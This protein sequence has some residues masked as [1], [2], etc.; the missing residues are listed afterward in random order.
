LRTGRI[1]NK[2]ANVS[3]TL[4]ETKKAMHVR[5]TSN[6]PAAHTAKYARYGSQ[7]DREGDKQND[8]LRI[9]LS[10]MNERGIVLYVDEKEKKSYKKSSSYTKLCLQKG[11]IHLDPLKKIARG[12][13]WLTTRLHNE[14]GE[15]TLT[16]RN[17]KLI[18]ALCENLQSAGGWINLSRAAEI[19]PDFQQELQVLYM[20][21]SQWEIKTKTF[22]EVKRSAGIYY[23]F[24]FLIFF[25]F[26]P[27]T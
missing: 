16:S 22:K 21:L 9:P 19:F 4:K 6:S 23:S 12:R 8:T 2:N 20:M 26:Q 1:P 24:S 3:V 27:K 14:Y 13:I 11:A 5:T 18:K 10:F 17:Q 15:I 7:Q 25:W